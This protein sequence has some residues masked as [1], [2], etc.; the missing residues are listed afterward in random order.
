MDMVIVRIIDLPHTVRG[1][2]VLDAEGDYNVY[3]NARLSG[4]Q[5]AIAFRHEVEHIKN[6]DF[7]RE[8][9]VTDKES[10]IPF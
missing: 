6:G 4:D 8:E 7:Y 3:L 5:Q 1:M 10:R 9:K 2:T